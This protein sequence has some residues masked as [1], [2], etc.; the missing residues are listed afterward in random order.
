MMHS[1]ENSKPLSALFQRNIETITLF[2]EDGL[3][4]SLVTL[5]G[6]MQ[7][8]EVPDRSGRYEN[9]LMTYPDMQMWEKNPFCLNGIIGPQAG[10]FEGGLLQLNEQTFFLETNHTGHHLHGEGAGFHRQVWQLE[11]VTSDEHRSTVVMTLQ[12]PHGLS[13][14]PGNMR[15]KATYSLHEQ[16]YLDIIFEGQSDRL[17][18]LNMTHHNYFN[19]SGDGKGPIDHH[20]LT[21]NA[22]YYHPLKDNG[23]PDHTASEVSG[24]C[25]DYTVPRPIS[26]AYVSAQGG[27]DHPF[28]L[29]RE[30]DGLVHAASLQDLQ[31]GRRL[32]VYTNQSHMVVYTQNVSYM[33]HMGICFE[34]QSFPDAPSLLYPGQT[35]YHKTRLV[36]SVE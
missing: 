9:I 21:L 32:Q 24:T 2:N 19:L 13:G 30:G 12:H 23:I 27:I 1:V 36:F 31:S 26:L 7:S 34:T 35:Y 6:I 25:F 33:Q 5:G 4:V 22:Q 15:L 14:F 29:E 3:K 8:V 18:H 20:L 28:R 17:S 11:S 16:G 10:R